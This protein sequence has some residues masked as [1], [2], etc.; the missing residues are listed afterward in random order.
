[1]DIV[2]VFSSLLNMGDLYTVAAVCKQLQPSDVVVDVDH[3]INF[4]SR[5]SKHGQACANKASNAR[6]E[7]VGTVL[8][9]Y[10]TVQPAL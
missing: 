6:D 10:P 5:M 9:H 8:A 7:S 1:M 2:D 3:L 4:S